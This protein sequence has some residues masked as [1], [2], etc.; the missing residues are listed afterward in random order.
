M[1]EYLDALNKEVHYLL[2]RLFL[3]FRVG[4]SGGKILEQI[5]DYHE[6]G[7]GDDGNKHNNQV[8]LM[9]NQVSQE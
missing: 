9:N 3:T 4:K 2:T 7:I 5:I 6:K 8:A 1:Q